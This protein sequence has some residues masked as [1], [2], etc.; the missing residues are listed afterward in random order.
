MNLL[1]DDNNVP[2]PILHTAN[3]Q[4][5]SPANPLA[6]ALPAGTTV[7]T[8]RAAPGT[9]THNVNIAAGQSVGASAALA[10]R[11][12][13]RL[14]VGANWTAADIT[15][16]TSLDGVTW[17]DLYD[18]TGAVYTIKAAAS[19]AIILP[20]SDLIGINHLRLRSGTPGAAINQAAAATLTLVAQVL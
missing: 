13:L 3:G 10:G 15:I 6:V 8:E 18:S 11:T 4:P 16:Q 1:T 9:T 14:I 20:V 7:T 17:A 19:R 2:L 5:V 12:P